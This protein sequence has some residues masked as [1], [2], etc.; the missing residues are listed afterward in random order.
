MSIEVSKIVQAVEPSA[1]LAMSAKAK[2]LVAAGH[3]VYN[4]SVG[5]PDFKT[6]QHI[7]DAAI[8]AMNAGHT[9]YTPATG[10]LPLKE[11]IVADFQAFDRIP[12]GDP[13]VRGR[14]VR[15]FL[16]QSEG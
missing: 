13:G 10:I 8:A 7:I 4:L 2:E 11:A 9:H 5:E 16:Y 14:S 12:G 1:T 3:K 6:P 15:A